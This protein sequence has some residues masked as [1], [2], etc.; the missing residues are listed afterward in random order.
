[1]KL[2]GK[3]LIKPTPFDAHEQIV[4][5]PHEHTKDGY[6]AKEAEF[7]E[8]PKAVAHDPETGAPVIA[9][10]ADHEAE[11]LDAMEEAK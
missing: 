3:E 6:V 7:A 8:Y 2:D 4:R 10:D 11:L 9:K 1:M 5:G